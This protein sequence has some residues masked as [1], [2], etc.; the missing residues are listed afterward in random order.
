M[1]LVCLHLLRES[2]AIATDTD[3]FIRRPSYARLLLVLA[4]APHTRAAL[5]VF[6]DTFL[7]HTNMIDTP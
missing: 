7:Q 1:L 6:R 4:M 3:G 5:V 2:H